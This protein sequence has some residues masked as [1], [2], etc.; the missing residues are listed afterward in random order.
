MVSVLRYLHI[1]LISMFA[2]LLPAQTPEP[3]GHEVEIQVRTKGKGSIVKRAEVQIGTSVQYTDSEGKARLTIPA[4]PGKLAVSRHGFEQRLIDFDELRQKPRFEVFLFPGEPGDNEVFIRGV[5]RPSASRKTISA[6]EAARVAPGGDPVQVTKLLPGV[7]TNSFGTDIAVRGSGPEDSL[8]YIDH[9]EVPGIFH[10]IAGLSVMP[11]QL[12]SDVEFAAGGFGPEYGEATGGVIVI[13][14]KTEIPEE[15]KSE[16]RV[17]I[18][19]YSSLFHERPVTT[20]KSL[21]LSFRRSYLE[22]FL[23]YILPKD[24]GPTV[25]PYFTDAHVLYTDK[26]D[27]GGHLKVLALGVSDGLKL[28]FDY[29]EAASDDGRGDISLLTDYAS[30]GAEKLQP[31]GQGWSYSLTPQVYYQRSRNT[32]FTD[33]V[34]WDYYRARLHY[35]LTKKRST[36]EFIYLGIEPGYGEFQANISAPVETDDPMFDYEDAPREELKQK[37]ISKDVATWIS[38][39][40]Q[41]SKLIVTPGVRGFYN[42]QIKKTGVDPRLNLRY[43]ASAAQTFKGAVGQY[44]KSPGPAEASKSFGNPD[45]DFEKAMHYVLGVESRWLDRWETDV[46]LY[47]KRI[48]DAIFPDA[49]KRYENSGII[50]SRGVELFVRRNL[51]EKAFGWVS[52][53]YS[54]TEEKPNNDEDFRAADFDQS[55]VVNLALSYRLTATWDLG[56]R[57]KYHTGD[58][59]T[60]IDD[61]VYNAN[62]DK[63]Q[64]RTTDEDA[65]SRRLP[66]FHQIDLFLTKDFLYNHWKMALRGGVNYLSFRKQVYAKRYNY[67]YSK[68]EDINDIPPIPFIEL[69]GEI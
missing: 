28:G 53:T 31:M 4:G 68:E 63:Y 61:A 48:R 39:D 5:K 11:D 21:A 18:P 43:E 35:E 65:N 15:S 42:D 7:Q 62:L 56:G 49:E 55:H 9:F 3:I 67:D 25:V 23:P 52:Y 64:P 20:N 24:N 14:T 12:I 19:F 54:Q 51:T 8:Y 57:F 13:K 22:L 66:P 32:F 40:Q 60:P 38:F 29:E 27:D 34:D 16:F 1:F 30:L 44:S 47:Y 59:Y 6:N 36:K 33:R 69:R 37:F 45:V 10:F 17:N 41:F 26:R 50:L 2:T 58:T 46:E